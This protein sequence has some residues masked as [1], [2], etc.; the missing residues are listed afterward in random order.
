MRGSAFFHVIKFYVYAGC[1]CRAFF[2]CHN[3]EIFNGRPN[4][5]AARRRRL[6]CQP[7]K[8]RLLLYD[9]AKTITNLSATPGKAHDGG[10]KL[11]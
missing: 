5:V 11:K 8:R 3:N 7:I 10:E 6:F 2:V 4:L 9:R 1:L